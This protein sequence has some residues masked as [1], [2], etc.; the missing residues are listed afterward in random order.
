[1]IQR[2]HKTKIPISSYPITSGDVVIVNRETLS[3]HG[4]IDSRK[5][6]PSPKDLGNDLVP[7]PIEKFYERF[8]VRA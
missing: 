3:V 8:A 7:Y 4:T 1:M 2:E 6:L 5:K